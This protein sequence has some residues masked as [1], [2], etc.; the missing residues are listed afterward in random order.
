MEKAATEGVYRIE[1]SGNLDRHAA[2]ALQL[3]IC[4]L[5]KRYG[6]EIQET[7]IE[8]VANDG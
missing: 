4:R 1:I 3:E 8:K 5:S 2:E 7:R 6:L